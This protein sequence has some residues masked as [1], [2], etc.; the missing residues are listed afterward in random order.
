VCRGRGIADHIPVAACHFQ[1][2]S[3]RNAQ[4]IGGVWTIIEDIEMS[5]GA[6]NIVASDVQTPAIQDIS[7]S[8]TSHN[9]SRGSF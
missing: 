4:K 6:F 3:V 9:I 1:H 7:S 2:H 8:N 5:T